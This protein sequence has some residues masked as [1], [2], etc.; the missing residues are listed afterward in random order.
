MQSEKTYCKN[1]NQKTWTTFESTFR[2]PL[3]SHH[4]GLRTICLKDIPP[5]EQINQLPFVFPAILLKS[6]ESWWDLRSGIHSRISITVMRT[7]DI[8]VIWVCFFSSICQLWFSVPEE[9]A[10]VW[11]FLCDALSRGW[12]H[13]RVAPALRFACFYP[14]PVDVVWCRVMFCDVVDMNIRTSE[15]F[16]KLKTVKICSNTELQIQHFAILSMRHGPASF[17]VCLCFFPRVFREKIAGSRRHFVPLRQKKHSDRCPK[18]WS[19]A[20]ESSCTVARPSRRSLSESIFLDETF[21]IPQFH[22][23]VLVRC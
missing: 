2:P 8:W 16:E 22:L 14:L 6:M 5:T 7:L 11:Q 19:L 3:C 9:S 4:F 20:A 21:D 17:F 18:G 1:H 12:S 10:A 15:A 13:C 23:A